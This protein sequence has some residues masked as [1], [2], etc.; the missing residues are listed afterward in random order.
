LRIWL[1]PAAGAKN[2]PLYKFA[3]QSLREV[4]ISQF[5]AASVR[6]EN[7]G[8][9]DIDTTT[10]ENYFSHSQGDRDQRFAIVAKMV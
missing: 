8:G 9:D 4:N 1:S 6:A 5:V 3:N 2:Y 7:I 10:D